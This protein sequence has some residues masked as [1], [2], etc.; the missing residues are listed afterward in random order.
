[1]NDEVFIIPYVTYDDI[2]YPPDS[3]TERN[4]TVIFPANNQYCIA[5]GRKNYINVKQIKD[6]GWSSD[7]KFRKIATPAFLFWI[8]EKDTERL[9]AV[10]SH[11]QRVAIENRKANEVFQE[12]YAK[13][14][15]LDLK[16]EA[17]FDAID[18]SIAW[19]YFADGFAY[20][21]QGLTH[22]KTVQIVSKIEQTCKKMGGRFYKTKAK[23]VKFALVHSN[24]GSL[25][26]HVVNLKNQGLKVATL[27]N[28]LEY[29]SLEHL[30]DIEAREQAFQ[31]WKVQQI[32]YYTRRVAEYDSEDNE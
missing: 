16:D 21:F 4:A 31:A 18:E 17:T 20:N 19:C 23:K 11:R 25:K 1:M 26:S 9:K 3:Y 12:E 13:S 6:L 30:F 15:L 10:L 24:Q 7:G 2:Y 5:N 8:D 28:A 14:H 29:F 32:N 22:R 27:E